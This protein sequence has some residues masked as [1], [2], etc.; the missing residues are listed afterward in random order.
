MK[1][2]VILLIFAFS[3]I[4]ASAQQF[5]LE[6]L[7]DRYL[8]EKFRNM[9]DYANIDGYP[10][11][12]RN[13]SEA[14]VVF[15][16]GTVQLHALRYNN[17][18]DE[19]EFKQNDV[20]THIANK[21]TIDEIIIND[22]VFKVYPLEKSNQSSFTYFIELVSGKVSLLQK[23]PIEYLPEKR[24]QGG[25]QDYLPPRFVVK[26]PVYFIKIQEGNPEELPSGKGRFL[27]YM[28]EKG[29]NASQIFNK[30][31]LKVNESGMKSLV[32][33]INNHYL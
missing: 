27:K 6:G 17:F 8:L 26:D 32:T 24:I 13:F 16:D 3:G 19:M 28:D 14:K 25:Y 33:E 11:L 5:T 23:A 10:Y 21:S 4:S 20:I 15:K 29:L 31:K 9:G 22:K 12:D 30:N 1:R 2:F 18:L 7:Y